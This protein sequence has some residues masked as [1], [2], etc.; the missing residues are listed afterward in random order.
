MHVPRGKE[1]ASHRVSLALH[2]GNNTN[3]VEI[4]MRIF[5]H[6]VMMAERKRNDYKS[7]QETDDD[8]ESEAE[9]KEGDY[10]SASIK[11]F[12]ESASLNDAA[13]LRIKPVSKSKLNKYR[14]R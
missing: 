3:L 14:G 13:L 4:A 5:H 10:E 7:D 1:V 6:N 9:V 8:Y 12:I 2:R 11:L